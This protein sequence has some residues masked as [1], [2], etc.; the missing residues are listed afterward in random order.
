MASDG[1]TI[2]YCLPEKLKNVCSC[3]TIWV[4]GKS[5]D[6]QIVIN[7]RS[8][9]LNG[10]KHLTPIHEREIFPFGDKLKWI[11]A[12]D[13]F[14]IFVTRSNVVYG[15]GQ[16]S[17]GQLGLDH[18]NGAKE[19]TRISFFDHKHIVNISCG[20]FF[21]YFLEEIGNKQNL[22]VCGKNNRGQLG[23]GDEVKDQNVFPPRTVNLKFLEENDSIDKIVCGYE[24]VL[25][26]SKKGIL[27]GCGSNGTYQIG[28]ERMTARI[29]TFTKCILPDLLHGEK[30]IDMSLG[31]SYSLLLTNL[32][33]VYYNRVRGFEKIALSYTPFSKI[34]HGASAGFLKFGK[35]NSLYPGLACIGGSCPS[36]QPLNDYTYLVDQIPEED[37]VIIIGGVTSFFFITKDYKVYCCGTNG[38]GEL[39]LLNHH[40]YKTIV[41]HY[42]MEEIIKNTRKVS[43]NVV[44]TIVAGY[45]HTILY[46]RTE[47]SRDYLRFF[48]NLERHVYNTTFLCDI[49]FNF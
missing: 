48:S 24:S 34:H 7:E 35:G 5:S 12:G 25:L 1:S 14:T 45:S 13:H 27:Y 43:G 38:W 28:A 37:E 22:F 19:I 11:G 15:A 18:C 3:E 30:V 23:L 6:G 46:F 31:T 32:G 39:G 41:R 36:E 4:C 16:N 47:E 8:A 40:D 26:L 9:I 21:S 42:E 17:C 44:P 49:T 29:S 10:V 33:N 2:D 20:A